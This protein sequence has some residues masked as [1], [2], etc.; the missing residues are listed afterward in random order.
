MDLAQLVPGV[1]GRASLQPLAGASGLVER[2]GPV[3]LHRL[4]LAA[5]NQALTAVRHQAR[6]RLAPVGQHA[7]PL[8]GARDVEHAHAGADD[9]AVGEPRDR[10][11]EVGGRDREHHL[12]EAAQRVLASTLPQQRPPHHEPAEDLEVGVAAQSAHAGGRGRQGHALVDPSELEQPAG[13][14][15]VRERRARTLHGVV[16]G[17]LPAPGQPRA[18]PG[19]LAGVD[20]HEGV[21]ERRLRGLGPAL[22]G[23]RQPVSALEDLGAGVVRAGHVER[24]AEQ[25]EVLERQ[26]LVGVDP[27]EA[28]HADVPAAFGVRRPPAL[29]LRLSHGLKVRPQRSPGD[30]RHPRLRWAP[31]DP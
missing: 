12:V 30:C 28:R 22:L 21:P 16:P 17:D 19:R 6:L 31:C 24:Q 4:E 8:L 14:D 2:L 10:G 18:A 11:I 29:Q 23:E 3:A 15:D 1:A 7:G 25:L 13:L 9:R 26:R 27:A 5:V 20:Q